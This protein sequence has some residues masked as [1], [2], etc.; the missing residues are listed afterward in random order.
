VVPAQ[1]R[2]IVTHRPN[3]LA[4]PAK[5]VV[6]GF[7]HRPSTLVE[8]RPMFELRLG[9]DMPARDRTV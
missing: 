2:V 3:M 1:F 7:L 5:R 9:R 8:P 6:Q 4:V